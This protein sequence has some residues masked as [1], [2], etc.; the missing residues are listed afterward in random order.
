MAHDYYRPG[1]FQFLKGG[2]DASG[3]LVA[4]ENHFV[5]YGDGD[6]F[7]SAGAMGATEFPQR[8]VPNYHLKA[9]VQPLVI[10]TGSLRA[11]SSN[12][13]AF[14]IQ[15]F[16]DEL[17]YAAG[18][19]PV[20]FRMAMLNTPPPPPPPAPAG[21]G[22]GGGFAAPGMNAERMK[23]VLQLVAEKSNW[24]KTKLP[25]GTAMGVAFHFSHQ[26]YF[27]EVA[28]VKVDNNKVKVNKVWVAVD[29]G[30][31]IINPSAAEN[32]IQG[33]IIDGLSE[34]MDQE[35]TVEKGR[36]VQ[37][38][39]HQHK[40]V[41][42]TQT[43]PEIEIHYLKTD[44]NPTGLGEP[45]LPPVLPAVANAIF[46]ATGKRLRSLPIAKSGLSWA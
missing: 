36:V 30:S 27:A 35:I 44:N 19:D 42:L 16:I 40:M 14:V 45:A 12:A 29:V 2:I 13:F 10:R 34:L 18:K 25:K 15:S 3:N 38:N 8:F 20:E 31:A 9:S 7:V 24:G 22:R 5:S 28:E 43:P 46:T 32:I 6:R 4:W 26:G 23:G 41:R 1:G 37:T 33:G 21:G 17:A 39:F 11:P